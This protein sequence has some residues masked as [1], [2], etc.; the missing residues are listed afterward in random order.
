M[1]EATPIPK[2]IA[3][4]TFG[5][6]AST[7][8]TEEIPARLRGL[9]TRTCRCSSR[10]SRWIFFLFDLTVLVVAQRHPGP[11]EP[12]AGMF[13]GIGAKP[14]PHLGVGIIRGLS[15]RE[16]AV[17]GA[18]QYAAQ[19]PPHAQR[20]SNSDVNSCDHPGGSN[21]QYLWIGLKSLS[22]PVAAVALESCLEGA[23]HAT[24]RSFPDDA[25]VSR[26]GC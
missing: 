6:S 13:G 16:A 24:C 17:G 20:S 22:S 8:G 21:C 4:T 14:G 3:H 7:G 1:T 23:C 18:G 26:E 9:C 5:A 10:H 25:D 11:A 12:V 15:L 2:S 19:F